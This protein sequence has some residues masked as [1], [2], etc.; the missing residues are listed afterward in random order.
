MKQLR[1]PIFNSK[2]KYYNLRI[3]PPAAV[4]D[5]VTEFKKEFEDQFGKLPLSGSKPHITLAQFK[6]N[7]KYEDLLIQVFDELSEEGKFKVQIDG[8]GVFENS[9]TFLLQICKNEVIEEIHKKLNHLRAQHLKRRL[10]AFSIS[11]IPHMTISKTTGK[12][13]LYESLQHFQAK[14]YFEDITVQYLSLVTRTK[15]RPW[16]LRH[17]IKLSE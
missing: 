15:Y 5:K 1:L 12:R 7:S 10:H 3:V 9:R 4:F 8:F 11:H 13:M 2:I 14:N 17:E 16:E 6:M